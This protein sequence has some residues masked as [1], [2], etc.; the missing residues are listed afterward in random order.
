MTNSY[1]AA[2]I[3]I[4]YAMVIVGLISAKLAGHI[5]WAW[6][7]VLSPLWAPVALCL[8]VLILGLVLFADATS[9]GKN[10]FQ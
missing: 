5:A 6:W 3:A 2:G 10:P 9:G 1:K 8:I 7:I 4:I